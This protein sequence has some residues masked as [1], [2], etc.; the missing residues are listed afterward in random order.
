MQKDRNQLLA[1]YF[2]IPDLAQL[3]VILVLTFI[4][5]YGGSWLLAPFSQNADDLHC[6]INL[7]L[8]LDCNFR[9]KG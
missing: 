2:E 9:F 5:F 1:K 4:T 7:A 3:V 8:K 6:G